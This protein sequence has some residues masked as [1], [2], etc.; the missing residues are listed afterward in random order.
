MVVG[1][2]GWMF[3]WLLV[4]WDGCW[5]GWMDVGMVVSVLGVGIDVGMVGVVGWLLGWWKKINNG[6]KKSDFS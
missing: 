3:G 5:G 1:V 6:W 2:V 4:C